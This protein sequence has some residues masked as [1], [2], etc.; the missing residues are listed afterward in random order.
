[1]EERKNSRKNDEWEAKLNE[2]RLKK[3]ISK[4]YDD[5][6]KWLIDVKKQ[7]QS[8]TDRDIIRVLRKYERKLAEALDISS[9]SS[10]EEETQLNYKTYSIV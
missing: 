3:Q 6:V 10:D 7:L 9:S 1:M 5:N 4:N 2:E 8:E